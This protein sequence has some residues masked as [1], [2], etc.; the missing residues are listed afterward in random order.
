MRDHKT[1]VTSRECVMA[2]SAT[3]NYTSGDDKKHVL[4]VMP[5][6][7]FSRVGKLTTV[8]ILNHLATYKTCCDFLPR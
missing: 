5:Q 7:A 8:V 4:P 6:T 3:R 1:R 2:S